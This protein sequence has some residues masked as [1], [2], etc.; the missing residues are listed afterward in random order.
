MISMFQPRPWLV[1]SLILVASVTATMTTGCS[2]GSDVQ[3]QDPLKPISSAPTNSTPPSSNDSTSAPKDPPI[4]APEP[5]AARY[6]I[7][8]HD[9]YPPYVMSISS[10]A[11][12][13]GFGAGIELGEADAKGKFDPLGTHNLENH[14]NPQ[15]VSL[16]QFGEARIIF[17]A[18][19]ILKNRS[20]TSHPRHIFISDAD[21]TARSGAA[22]ML[23]SEISPSSAAITVAAR[24]NLTIR[25]FGVSDGGR[26]LLIGQG[27]GYRLLDSK[28]L[29]NLGTLKIGGAGDNL[30]PALRESDMMFSVA[31][32]APASF[33]SK[34]YSVGL[35]TRGGVRRVTRVSTVAS[36]RRPLVAIGVNAA[37]SFAALD[38]LNRIVIVSPLKPAAATKSM[39]TGIPAKGRLASSVAFWRESAGLRAVIVFE[40]FVLDSASVGSRSYK[41][42]QVFVRVLEVDESK[43]LASALTEDLDY[44]FDSRRP[45][46]MGLGANLYPGVTEL[47][48]LHDGNAIFGL[49]PGSLSNQLYRLTAMGL[50]RVSQESCTGLSIGREL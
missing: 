20:E 8:C 28:T 2:Q 21:I 34:L 22:K 32:A 11:S 43:R 5:L 18:R 46:E 31:S 17:S 7:F 50:E 13:T 1:V 48:A 15:V 16:P 23:A 9:R 47:R 44:P 33:T 49:F 25:T 30:N 24:E 45:V 42:E 38:T 4:P 36:L 10:L 37:E 29:R 41:I 19:R 40:D 26:Y 39:I 6:R 12:A 35:D 27:D 3:L 14:E